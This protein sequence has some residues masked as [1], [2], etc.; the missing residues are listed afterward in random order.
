[1]KRSG[2][3]LWP[4]C[5]DD[6]APSRS[7]QVGPARL[8]DNVLQH[9]AQRARWV[10]D[11][12]ALAAIDF[13]NEHLL[14]L[15]P[16]K[17]KERRVLGPLRGMCQLTISTDGQWGAGGKGVFG[18]EG[19]V[20]PLPDGMPGP[21]LP[22]CGNLMFSPDSQWLVTEGHDSFC[23]WRVGT[24]RPERTFPKDQFDRQ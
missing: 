12:G 24:W 3:C 10:G 1:G 20:W 11:G 18:Y 5:R 21:D 19:K 6:H 22:G 9:T 15:N 23:F 13:R 16:D 8:L 7:L 17:P 4:L 14:I 2:L